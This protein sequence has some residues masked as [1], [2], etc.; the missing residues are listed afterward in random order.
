MVSDL[1]VQPEEIATATDPRLWKMAHE[2]M[3]SRAEIAALKSTRQQQQTAANH[4]KAQGTKPAATPK[5]AGAQPR[6]PSTPRGDGLS[7]SEWM[8]RRNAKFAKA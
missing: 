5:G 3:T 4:E 2:I 7:T 1:G 6:D 8:R